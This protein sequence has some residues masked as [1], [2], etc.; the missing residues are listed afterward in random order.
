MKFNVRWL[1]ERSGVVSA[2]DAKA[3]ERE[4]LTILNRTVGPGNFKILSI[5]PDEPKAPTPIASAA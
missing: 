4:T 1:E 3:A 5:V 2:A